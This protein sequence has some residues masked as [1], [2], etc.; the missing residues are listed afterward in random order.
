[1]GGFGRLD[2]QKAISFVEENGTQLE[3]YRLSYLLGEE[4]DDG[5]PLRFLKGLQNDDGG[6][7]YK[8]EKGKP[9]SVNHTISNLNHD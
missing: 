8:G 4:R 1:M 5:V 9:S 6:F 2:I 7:P 3:R